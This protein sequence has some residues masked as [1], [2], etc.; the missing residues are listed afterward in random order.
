[1]T[2]FT[3]AKKSLC[4][5]ITRFFPLFGFK[6][7]GSPSMMLAMFLRTV[8]TVPLNGQTKHFFV[9]LNSID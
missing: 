6:L 1:M 2:A 7:Y 9:A 3:E 8:F 4:Y 5:F